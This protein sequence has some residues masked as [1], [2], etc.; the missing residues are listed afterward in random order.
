[1]ERTFL[2]TGSGKNGPVHGSELLSSP[3]PVDE[4]VGIWRITVEVVGGWGVECA[5][6]LARTSSFR[7]TNCAKEL[8]TILN[9][10]PA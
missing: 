3:A 5:L 8:M 1:M 7:P 2:R 6:R 10:D 4:H 9:K